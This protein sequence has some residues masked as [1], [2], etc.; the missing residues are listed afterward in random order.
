MRP[1]SPPFGFSTLTTSAPSWASTSVQVGPAS[2]C[3]RSSTRT[4]AR[5]FGAAAASVIVGSF[6]WLKGKIM[7]QR[8]GRYGHAKVAKALGHRGLCASFASFALKCFFCAARAAQRNIDGRT[9][10][11]QAVRELPVRAV[12]AVLCGACDR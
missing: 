10:S 7:L 9:H 5:Q 4:P 3:D 2:N 8:E 11:P 1:G 6:S 12:R